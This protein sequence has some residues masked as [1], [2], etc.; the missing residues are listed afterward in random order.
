MKILIDIGHP[1][2]V[3]LFKNF[4]NEMLR[5]GHTL[6]F[7]VRE[8]ENESDLLDF[9]RF[10]YSIIGKKQKGLLSRLFYLLL[11]IFRILICARKFKPDL[12]LSHGSMY[13]AYSAFLTFKK[14]ISLEDS[15]NM[16]QIRLYKMFTS[17]I[18]TPDILPIDLGPRQI[19]YSGYHELMYLLPKYFTPNATIFGVLGISPGEQYAILRFVSWEATHD[20]NQRGL[21][22]TEKINLVSEL[23]K[24]M[25]V[26][27]SGERKLPSEL[28][29]FRLEIPFERI[30]DALAFAKVYIGEGATMASEAGILGVPSVYI[31]SIERCYNTDQ[32]KFGTV[33]NVFPSNDSI[34]TILKFI[35]NINKEKLL[36]NRNNLLESKID[37]TA[38]LVWFVENYPQ[39]FRI[40]KENPDYQNNFK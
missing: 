33:F 13:A 35:N 14:H 30:H 7:T 19:K 11:Y 17:T 3:H 25:K 20:N 23:S 10:N 1:A 4:A 31:S 8:G 39:S 24:Q 21:S 12:Y 32:G 2:H 26:F 15:G 22:V 9:Y 5:R 40:M 36:L 29:K 6:F 18:I 28:E 16:E 34:N 27:I 38:F 37:P